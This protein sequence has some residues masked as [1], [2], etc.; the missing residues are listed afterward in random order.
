MLSASMHACIQGNPSYPSTAEQRSI[1]PDA[2]HSRSTKALYRSA[3]ALFHL[4]TPS[5]LPEALQLLQQ[6]EMLD[7][8][9]SEVRFAA[10]QWWCRHMITVMT[11]APRRPW[12]GSTARKC[13]LRGRDSARVHFATLRKSEVMLQCRTGVRTHCNVAQE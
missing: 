1:L 3:V 7:P 10:V 11:Y 12:A 2:W 6:A 8:K 4:G 5:R 13:E 9:S